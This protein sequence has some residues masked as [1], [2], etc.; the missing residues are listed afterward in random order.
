M[1]ATRENEH[2]GSYVFF[3]ALILAFGIVLVLFR[4]RMTMD[5]W[6]S[7]FRVRPTE[8]WLRM[9]RLGAVLMGLLL[10]VSGLVLVVSGIVQW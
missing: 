8:G 6:V 1:S 9:G 7:F 3:G 4:T 5:Y 2:W 10:I